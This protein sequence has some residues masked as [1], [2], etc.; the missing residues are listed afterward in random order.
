MYILKNEKKK[1]FQKIV[2]KQNK[3]KVKRKT[4]DKLNIFANKHQIFL[5]RYP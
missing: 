3:L 1:K 4:E 5:N 2:Y